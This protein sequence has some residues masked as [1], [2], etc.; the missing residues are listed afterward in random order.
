MNSIFQSLGSP[1]NYA[2]QVQGITQNLSAQMPLLASVGIGL[3]MCATVFQIGVQADLLTNQMLTDAG[4][5]TIAGP[6]CL[7][8]TAIPLPSLNA[9][10]LGGGTIA[11]VLGALAIVLYLK[12]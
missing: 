1:T 6:T 9:L 7:D 3:G 12:K 5:S 10:A 8:A 4:Q 2:A 11:L